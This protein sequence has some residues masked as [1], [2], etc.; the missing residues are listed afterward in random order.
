MRMPF[1]TQSKQHWLLQG[2]AFPA[3]RRV[4]RTLV[5][6]EPCPLLPVQLACQQP[7]LLPGK[8]LCP[9]MQQDLCAIY[10]R[11]SES[12]HPGSKFF[13][14]TSYFFHSNSENKGKKEI[15]L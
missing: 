8:W 6:T 15:P 11:F 1:E 10:T 14:I 9:G 3:P 5:P 4:Q 12:W 13:L 2:P 7:L